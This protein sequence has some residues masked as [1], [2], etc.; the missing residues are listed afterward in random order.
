[1]GQSTDAILAYG[2]DLGGNEDEWRIKN[3]GPCGT[4]TTPW[5]DETSDDLDEEDSDFADL[6]EKQ[7]RNVPAAAGVEIVSHCSSSSPLYILAATHTIAR[8]GYPKV[9][10]AAQVADT[11]A[12]DAR[13]AA[14]CAALGIEPADDRPQWLLASDAEM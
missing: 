12:M 1:M 7:L 4:L 6:V 9:I 11:A 14:A 3:L 2:Y 10:D 5:Y 13:L 8:R